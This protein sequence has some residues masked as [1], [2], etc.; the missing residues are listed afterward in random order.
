MNILALDTSGP[1]VSVSILA[2]ACLRYEAA[3]T[4][5][6]THSQCL[7]PMVENALMETQMSLA[8]M[9]ALAAVVGPG[10]FTGVRIGVATVQGLARA[11]NKPCLGINALEALAAGAGLQ[12]GDIAICPL[13]DAR[14][15]QV[16]AAAFAPG[17]PPAS[18]LPDEALP[19]AD[20][21]KKCASL[22]RPL[23]FLGD[24]APVFR[25]AITASLGPLA[26]FAPPHLCGLRAG[27]VAVLAGC[28]AAQAATGG[29]LLPY[30]L[31]APQAERERARRGAGCG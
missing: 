14:A 21:L 5:G 10:S 3:L 4:H 26:S 29:A 15:G 12:Q 16:Y 13:L 9:D 23:L 22:G 2:G 17:L 30:Y 24:G 18:L 27:A 20:F 25:Q 19:L 11:S 31:R 8:D 28:Y 7:M 6:R 1:S